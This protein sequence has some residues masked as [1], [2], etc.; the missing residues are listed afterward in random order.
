MPTYRNDTQ[1]N[2]QVQGIDGNMVMVA[3]A[4]TIQTHQILPAADWTKISDEPYYNIAANA[5]DITFSGAETQSQAVDP[6]NHVLRVSTD[7]NLTIHANS[8]SAEG[9]PLDAD[10]WIDIKHEGNIEELYLVSEGAGSAKIIE[11]KD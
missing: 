4:E 10:D 5:H 2:H 8:A 1:E 3:P 9:Y 7:V 6:D 11:I